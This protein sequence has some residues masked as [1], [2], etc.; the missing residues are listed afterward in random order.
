V[1]ILVNGGWSHMDKP[2]LNV[3]WLIGALAF[4]VL[5]GRTQTNALFASAVATVAGHKIRLLRFHIPSSAFDIGGFDSSQFLRGEIGRM[6]GGVRE[7]N[8]KTR[9]SGIHNSG[10]GSKHRWLMKL[11]FVVTRSLLSNPPRR[12][13]KPRAIR[14]CVVTIWS[15]LYR[16]HLRCGHFTSRDE[17]T[18]TG[19]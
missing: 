6:F 1:P 18:L 2:P 15:A 8:G 7:W 13:S 16:L 3:S 14:S 9:S 4:M 19:Q 10:L 12:L 11:V 5:V 17:K